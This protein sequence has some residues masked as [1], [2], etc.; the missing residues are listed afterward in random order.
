MA[1][2]DLPDPLASA[3]PNRIAGRRSTR[4]WAVSLLVHSAVFAAL[5]AALPRLIRGLAAPVDEDAREV[6][7]VLK[8]DVDDPVVFDNP[9]RTFREPNEAAESDAEALEFPAASATGPSSNPALPRIDASLLGVGD[10]SGTADA[11]ASAP[12]APAGGRSRT[13][14]WNVESVGSSFVFVIDRSASMAH[15]GALELAKEQLF[16]SLALLAKENRFQVI[17]YNT[18]PQSLDFAD[19]GLI[20][21]NPVNVARAKKLVSQI[22]PE[23]GTQHTKPLELAFRYRPE[24]VYFLTDADMFSD[25]DVDRMTGVNRR[26]PVPASIF[27]IEFGNGP[28]LS[29]QKPLRRLAAENDGTYSYVDVQSFGTSIG[30]PQ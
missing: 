3:D 16:Q 22:L 7:I 14:F 6:G 28:N 20:E 29:P 23:G 11:F 17:F 25:E 5:F 13:T 24:V 21:A 9:E 12:S 18:E 19:G 27:A 8:S 4:M 26:A 15:R 10:P 1:R 30:R 2:L